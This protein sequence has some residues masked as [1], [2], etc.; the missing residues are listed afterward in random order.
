MWFKQVQLFQLTVPIQSSPSA[1]AERLEALAFRPCLPT[2]PSSVGFVS[3]LDEEE[4]PLARGINGCIMICLQIE[5]KI[6][7]GTVVSL[8]LKEK[9][10]Q[11]ELAEARKI[12]Q[13]EKLSFKDEVIHTLLPRAFSKFTRI[14]A[15]LDTRHGWLILNSTG[16][17]KTELFISMIKK[18]LGDVIEPMDIIKP[19]VLLTPWLK[20]QDYPSVF[21]V[22][23]SCVLQDPNQQNRMIRCQ[24]QDL[25]AESIQSLVKEGCDVIQLALCWHDKLNFII[26]DDLVLRSIRL[27][28]DDLVDFKDEIETKQQKFDA[29]FV[30]MTEIFSGLFTDLLALFLK[31]AEMNQKVKLALTG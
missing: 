8:A 31:G 26:S 9:V 13:K 7:P 25:F 23:K 14:Y 6:L 19:S 18:S 4:A 10:K 16:P 30:M 22:E 17:A 27:A 11:I 1:L 3:P 24:Q 5:E 12:R 21:S 15:Y 28:D 20:N 2:M 29:D